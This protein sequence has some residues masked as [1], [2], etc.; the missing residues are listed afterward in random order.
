MQYY[1]GKLYVMTGENPG[2]VWSY[3]HRLAID[4]D[5]TLSL[6]HTFAFYNN[7]S[8]HI[9]KDLMYVLGNGSNV[10]VTNGFDK[11]DSVNLNVVMGNSGN[12][13]FAGPT[14]KLVVNNKIAFGFQDTG[15]TVYNLTLLS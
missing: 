7:I 1:E 11:S 3:L 12:N 9:D 6:E 13:A 15:A 8:F 2:T 5:G 4:T 10:I 14:N